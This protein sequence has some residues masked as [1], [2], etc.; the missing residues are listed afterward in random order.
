MVAA[1]T[2]IWTRESKTTVN[3]LVRAA[4][5]SLRHGVQLDAIVV[6]GSICIGH[7]AGEDARVLGDL[8]TG[9]EV[10]P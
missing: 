6:Y 8:F 3:N 5:F 7:V 9:L 4:R 10:N 1:T 2:I